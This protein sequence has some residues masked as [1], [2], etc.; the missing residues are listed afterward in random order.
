MVSENFVVTESPVAG[1]NPQLLGR[2]PGDRPDR[3]CEAMLT[4]FPSP[5]LV[6][7]LRMYMGDLYFTTWVMGTCLDQNTKQNALANPKL[8]LTATWNSVKS[9]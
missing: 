7:S 8:Y 3:R 4:R 2:Y 1:A 5:R 6:R 9:Y